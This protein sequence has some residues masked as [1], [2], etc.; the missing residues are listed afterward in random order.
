MNLDKECIR[1][2]KVDGVMY[3]QVPE[4]RSEECF[5]CVCNDKNVEETT[6]HPACNPLG[7]IESCCAGI[8]TTKDHKETYLT[9]HVLHK[10]EGAQ[11]ND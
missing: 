5:G 7:T 4:I 8:W 11:S 9:I 3:Y 2:T 10:L 6:A 1:K